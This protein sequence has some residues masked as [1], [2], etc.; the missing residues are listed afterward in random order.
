MQPNIDSYT[1]LERET[2]KLIPEKFWGIMQ[3]AM[4]RGFDTVAM[5]RGFDPVFFERPVPT[6]LETLPDLTEEE[7]QKID[8]EFPEQASGSVV[9][10]EPL[11]EEPDFVVPE[12]AP[13]EQEEKSAGDFGFNW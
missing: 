6:L 2:S 4:R 8:E 7:N 1:Q 13:A 11:T 12:E 5:A 3:H 10:G 9:T